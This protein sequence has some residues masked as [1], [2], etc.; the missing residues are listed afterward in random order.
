MIHQFEISTGIGCK[1]N[2]SYCPQSVITKA[3]KSPIKLM[4]LDTFRKCIDKVPKDNIIMFAGLSEP[5]LNPECIHMIMYCFINGFK[6][7]V[8][9]TCV[10]MTRGD[11]NMIDYLE[12]KYGFDYFQIHTPDKENKTSI[13]VDDKH[14]EILK[15]IKEIG[16]KN[17]NY[18]L[19]GEIHPKV[20]ETWGFEPEDVSRLLQNRAG[21][22]KENFSVPIKILKGK[23]ICRNQIKDIRN[24][25]LLP[26]GDLSLCCMDY[27]LEYV[28]GNLF[29]SSYEDLVKSDKY[30]TIIRNLDDDKI[31]SLCRNCA[32]GVEMNTIFDKI[33]YNWSMSNIKREFYTLYKMI[34]S[35][36]N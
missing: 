13:K 33:K 4:T 10:G 31:K 29:E 23:I 26:N 22:L 30:K 9:T 24:F 18:Q 11:V 36:K 14:I 27:G 28:I 32:Y 35:M 7:Q 21:N 2:C 16:I 8:F 1:N 20:K 25:L 34:E 3:Y 5:F 17:V 19:F 15:A 6:V 12:K